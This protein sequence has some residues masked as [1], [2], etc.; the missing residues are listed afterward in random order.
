M[1]RQ[2]SGHDSQLAD[3]EAA[4]L[5]SQKGSPLHLALALAWALLTQPEEPPGNSMTV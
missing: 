1:Q 4:A 3:A 2:S 5:A